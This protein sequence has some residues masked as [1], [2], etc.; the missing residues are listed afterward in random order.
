MILLE[1]YC[2]NMCKPT[3]MLVEFNYLNYA[4]WID[5]DPL[6]MSGTSTEFTK[7][8][9]N[10]VYRRVTSNETLKYVH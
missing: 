2:L 6:E 10:T 5:D 3:N 8:Y 1:T 4:Y 9:N 7:I